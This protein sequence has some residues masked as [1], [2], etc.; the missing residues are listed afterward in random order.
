M[1][2]RPLFAA[3]AAFAVAACATAPAEAPRSNLGLV[4]Y[5]DDF[6]AFWERTQHL[7]HAER[8]AACEA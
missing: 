2:L 4:D 8:I 6:A 7:P 1:T 5:T 3:A